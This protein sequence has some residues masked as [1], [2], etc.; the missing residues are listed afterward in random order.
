[1]ARRCGT[2]AA[3]SAT[4]S[5]RWCSSATLMWTSPTCSPVSPATASPST[6]SPPSTSSLP[7]APGRTTF[8]PPPPSVSYLLCGLPALRFL[9]QTV[10]HGD[11]L[12]SWKCFAG[13]ILSLLSWFER[14]FTCN[15]TELV[16]GFTTGLI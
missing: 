9:N 7:H 4:N 12:L 8:A 16:W 10:F 11:V 2:R 1:M 15:H 3:T 6:P 13:D 14:Y 5:S